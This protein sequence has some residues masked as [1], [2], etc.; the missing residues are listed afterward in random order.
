[1]ARSTH[2]DHGYVVGMIITS[3]GDGG[4]ENREPDA[5]GRSAAH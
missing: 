1:M 5:V 3:R 4:D 2:F